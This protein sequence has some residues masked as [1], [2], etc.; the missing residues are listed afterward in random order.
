MLEVRVVGKGAKECIVHLNN[1]AE[2]AISDNI[3]IRG[4][5]PGPFICL[6]ARAR[7]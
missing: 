5:E 3:E 7:G 2:E 1:A 6:H 4:P